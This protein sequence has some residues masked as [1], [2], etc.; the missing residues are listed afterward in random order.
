MRLTCCLALIALVPARGY[1]QNPPPDA[2]EGIEGYDAT[3]LSTPA[4][5]F[6]SLIENQTRLWQA[7]K[8]GDARSAKKIVAG[9]LTVS[10]F[11]GASNGKQFVDQIEARACTV[12]SFKLEDFDIKKPNQTSL[13]LT[14]NATQSAVCAGKT[15]PSSIRVKVGYLNVSGNWTMA[16]Y[17]ENDRSSLKSGAH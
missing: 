8:N 7:R 16:Y 14:Y 10:S 5:T 6:K 3:R 9:T 1:A 2:R 11:T 13:L 17:L 4:P 12:S 15:L